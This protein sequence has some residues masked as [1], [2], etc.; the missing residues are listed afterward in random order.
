MWVGSSLWFINPLFHQFLVRKIEYDDE[1]DEDED[2]EDN[3]CMPAI[4]LEVVMV[5]QD[6]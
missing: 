5:D 4:K 6:W 2:D 1:D 3:S